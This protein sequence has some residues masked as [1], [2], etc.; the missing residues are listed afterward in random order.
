MTSLGMTPMQTADQLIDRVLRQARKGKP[1]LPPTCSTPSPRGAVMPVRQRE[2]QFSDFAAVAALKERWGHWSDSLANWRR[3]WRDNPALEVAKVPLGMGW[4]LE[5][6]G[7]IVGYS[8]S[9]P[10]LYHLR[11]R[12]LIAAA[13]TSLVVAPAYRAGAVTLL[14]SFYRQQGIDLFLITTAI[15]SVARL[16]TTLGAR[17]L[18]QRDYST[19]L[20]WVLDAREV[21][22]ALVARLG[23]SGTAGT[24]GAVLA[25]LAQR[26]EG[27]IRRRGP[28]H[29]PGSLS[30]SEIEPSNI[31]EDFAVLWQRRRADQE[32]LLRDRSPASLK[33]HFSIPGGASCATVLCCHRSGNLVGY[34]IVRHAA[35]QA[36][37]LRRTLLADIV[38]ERDDPGVAEDLL[39][40]A[41]TNARSSGSHVFEVLGF[42]DNIR[43]ILL[44]WNPYRRR[45]PNNPFFYKAPDRN[46]AGILADEAAWYAG[47]L[48]GD[49]TLMS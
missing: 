36:T 43:R 17:P 30:I 37:G 41:Y 15:A 5:A 34:A 2:V 32:C 18:P 14:S 49:T 1:A 16:S 42:P 48:D 11:G 3:L 13:G 28:G 26:T 29:G 10:L 45:Y 46:L 4:V 21:A 22:R 27:M 12:P 6:G 24:V 39:A 31:G 44:N 9:I 23:W 47:P 25:A 35:E 7:E 20:F 40:A 33:W 8:G 38:V 19:V